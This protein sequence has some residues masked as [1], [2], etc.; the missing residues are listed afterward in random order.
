MK[1]LFTC[2]LIAPFRVGLYLRPARYVIPLESNPL[3]LLLHTQ[4]QVSF[5]TKFSFLFPIK[6]TKMTTIIGVTKPHIHDITIS[7][8]DMDKVINR[9]LTIDDFIHIL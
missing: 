8:L 9:H 4:L 5:Y 7:H 2:M 3:P 1:S 6:K